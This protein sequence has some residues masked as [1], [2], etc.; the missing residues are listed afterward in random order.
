MHFEMAFSTNRKLVRSLLY[1]ITVLYH[2]GQASLKAG[3]WS[4]SAS[5]GGKVSLLEDVVG[6]Q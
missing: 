2:K 3:V 4:L 6:L 5:P 1:S